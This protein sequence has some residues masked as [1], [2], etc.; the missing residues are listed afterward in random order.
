MGGVW[1]ILRGCRWS[2]DV[3]DDVEGL[4]DSIQFGLRTARRKAFAEEAN[5]FAERIPGGIE[6]VQPS[7]PRIDRITDLETTNR[8]CLELEC[9]CL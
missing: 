1:R 5:D 8:G 4:D 3:T 9:T 7:A 6:E 2:S